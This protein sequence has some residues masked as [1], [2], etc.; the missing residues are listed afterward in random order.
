MSKPTLDP[1]NISKAPTF[2][3]K[4]VLVFSEQKKLQIQSPNY[5]HKHVK[6]I[7]ATHTTTQKTAVV[8]QSTHTEFLSQTEIK[9]SSYKILPY[10]ALRMNITYIYNSFF[11]TI[12]IQ[13]QETSVKY[14]SILI[15][16]S[17]IFLLYMSWEG[18]FIFSIHHFV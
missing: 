9:L 16:M 11:Q 3:V 8:T 12:D 2:Q 10:R 4:I 7:S 6:S 17:D 15:L 5:T 1:L 18:C 13:L 14:L